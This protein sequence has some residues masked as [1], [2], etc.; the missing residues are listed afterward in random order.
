MRRNER[1]VQY[2]K[3]EVENMYVVL[4]RI[5]LTLLIKYN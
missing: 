3:I 2:E 1:R 4:N 5:Q